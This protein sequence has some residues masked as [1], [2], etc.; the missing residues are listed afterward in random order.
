MSKVAKLSVKMTVVRSTFKFSGS[1]GYR[2]LRIEGNVLLKCNFVLKG[3][4][5]NTVL[6]KLGLFNQL[7]KQYCL[8]F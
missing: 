6:H 3:L 8:N 4:Q 5:M 7:S 2:T 1:F